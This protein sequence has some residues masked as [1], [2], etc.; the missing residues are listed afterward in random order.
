ML[1]RLSD[2]AQ[3]L[4]QINNARSFVCLRATFW[5]QQLKDHQR[6]AQV[7][8]SKLVVAQAQPQQRCTK[9]RNVTAAKHCHTFVVSLK[10]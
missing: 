7:S 4:P 6:T 5:I 8:L 3:H 9:Q 2:S 1:Q 10:F